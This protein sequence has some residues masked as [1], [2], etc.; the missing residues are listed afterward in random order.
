MLTT[1][2]KTADAVKSTQSVETMESMESVGEVQKYGK[3]QILASAKYAN[4]RD[5]IN[6]LLDDNNQY[7]IDEVEKIVN[8]FMKGK[9]K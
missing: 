7:T 8:G 5:L 3:V 6:A 9:V 4:R 2:N 1:K